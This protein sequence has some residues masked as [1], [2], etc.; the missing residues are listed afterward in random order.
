MLTDRL[1]RAA[2]PLIGIAVNKIGPHLDLV[3]GGLIS[4]GGIRGA[5]DREEHLH[6]GVHTLGSQLEAVGRLGI[7]REITAHGTAD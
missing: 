1:D 2:L 7:G 3:G 5:Q 6:I 4:L